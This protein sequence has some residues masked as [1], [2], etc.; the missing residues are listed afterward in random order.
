VEILKIL[1]YAVQAE[2]KIHS[3]TTSQ[4]LKSQILTSHL[5]LPIRQLVTPKMEKSVTDIKF[6]N[7]LIKKKIVLISITLAITRANLFA[8]YSEK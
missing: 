1:L 4:H 7:D 5:A 8:S 2:G 6:S 3:V